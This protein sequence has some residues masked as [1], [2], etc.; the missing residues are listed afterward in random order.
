[1]LESPI[2]HANWKTVFL[3]KRLK[4]RKKKFFFIIQKISELFFEFRSF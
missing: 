4:K 3:E 1:M 2:K